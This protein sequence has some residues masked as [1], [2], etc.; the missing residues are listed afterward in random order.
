[1]AEEYPP[2]SYLQD[3]KPKGLFIDLVHRIQEKLDGECSEVKFYPW[4]RGYKKLQAGEGDVLFPMC[5]TTERSTMFKF[6]GPVFW[7]DI[8]FYRKKGSN[9]ELKNFDDAKKVG[10]IA[11]TRYDVFH[12]NLAS[13]G[14][15]N[16][17]FSASPKFDFMKLLRDRVDLVPMGRKVISYF[18]E[19]NPELDFN[20]LE[21]VG[22]PV[23]FTSNYIAFS[24]DTPDEI[25]RKWQRALEQL[26]KEGE[27]LEIV[28]KYFPPDSVD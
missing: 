11:V 21:R 6:V 2:Y 14:Y 3:G 8:Y 4:A 18:F 24:I 26:K 25:V 5:M 13:M 27:W 15:T 28:D 7:D 10:K 1:M 19:R 16:L 20:M 22:P 17:D 23:F 12:Q 9:I